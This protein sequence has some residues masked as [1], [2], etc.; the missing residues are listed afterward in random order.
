MGFRVSNDATVYFSICCKPSAQ[1]STDR[2]SHM[3]GLGPRGL[4]APPD[5]RRERRDARSKIE[6]KAIEAR[7]VDNC[8]HPN[9]HM[10]K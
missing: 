7:T 5:K 2:A 9:S 1:T 3:V 4:I 6:E 10:F 8:S